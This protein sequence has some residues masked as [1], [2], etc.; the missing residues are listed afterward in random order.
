[1]ICQISIAMGQAGGGQRSIY[2]F[3]V[4]DELFIRH[5]MMYGDFQPAQLS[6]NEYRSCTVLGLRESA[7]FVSTSADDT[8]TTKLKEKK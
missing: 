7:Q 4:P 1:M 2:L 5:M 3:E 6:D 8:A